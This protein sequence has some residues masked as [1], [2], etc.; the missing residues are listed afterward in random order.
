MWL[1]CCCTCLNLQHAFTLYQI[2]MQTFVSHGDILTVWVCHLV[3]FVLHSCWAE[4]GV[5]L[6]SV[7]GE[8]VL[9]KQLKGFGGHSKRDCVGEYVCLL[10]TYSDVNG[11]F[12]KFAC[13]RICMY[14]SHFWKLFLWYVIFVGRTSKH[15]L[16][17]STPISSIFSWL[18]IK[19]LQGRE[20]ACKT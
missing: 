4:W 14:E 10:L 18:I 3:W 12:C 1:L 13:R 16:R 8:E 19:E 2:L 11:S 7:R 5:C 9:L 17:S 15:Q 6:T 20:R